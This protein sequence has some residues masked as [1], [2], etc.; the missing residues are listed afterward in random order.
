M[1]LILDVFP[2][3]IGEHIYTIP[4]VVSELRDSKT[5]QRLKS[6]LFELTYKQPSPEALN[7]GN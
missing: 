3:E 2:Q 7:A 1:F 6:P 4:E 5:R